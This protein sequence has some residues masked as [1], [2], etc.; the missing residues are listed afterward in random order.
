MK[1]QIK[2]LTDCTPS[3]MVRAWNRGFNGYAVNLEM[4]ETMFL[5]RLVTEEL[6]PEHSIVA[7]I[8]DEPVGIIMN[9]F[10][11]REG[12]SIA[13]NGG[14][15]V[16]PEYRG[17][18]IIHQ[19]MERTMAI[20]EQE[21]VEIANL[22]AIKSNETAIKLYGKYGYT[23]V[24]NLVFL[25]GKQKGAK[26]LEYEVCRP[27]ELITLS[28]YQE[29]VVWQ[30][31]PAS[32]KH[33]EAYVFKIDEKVVGYSLFRRVWDEAKKLSRVNIYQLKLL[34]DNAE[35]IPRM[36]AAIGEKDTPV[37]LVNFI[38]NDPVTRY[39]LEQDFT[40]T[41]EQVWMEKRV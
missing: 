38:K 9:G 26:P 13:W 21:K 23:V 27:E 18:G 36:L 19:L 32:I 39:L 14:T 3:E 10:R 1:M 34:A 29:R 37:M 11:M 12:Q 2:K 5:N 16:A 41:A 24:E 17:S 6:S 31:Q 40:V 25:L 30:C 22:E 4:D 28:G 8:K 35:Y 20:Y 15:A 7:F 33:G